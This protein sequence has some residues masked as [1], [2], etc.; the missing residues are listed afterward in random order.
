MGTRILVLSDVHGNLVALEKVLEA[1]GPVD[2]IWS[3]GDIVGYGPRPRECVDR[4]RDICPD[5]SLIG[6]HD[7]A[8]I[9]RLSLEDFNPIARFA[10]YWTTMQLT[11]EHLQYLESLP[12]RMIDQDW[13]LVHGSPRHP[14]WEY[15]YNARIAALNFPLLDTRICFLGHTHVQMY[16]REEDALA[17]LP[18]RQ[19]I[20]GQVLDLSQGR[21][22]LNPGAVGQPRD[23][24]P[25]AAFA[26]FEPEALRVTFRRVAYDVAETQAQMRAEGLPESLASRLKL[27]I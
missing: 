11:A 1:A 7:W 23:G 24:D 26:I 4:I 17:N 3:L 8:C 27:G 20:E 14:V 2:A 5:V 22:M 25:R 16:I 10:S 9:G 19:P 6:N 21:F 12:N 13:T 15:V 18:P